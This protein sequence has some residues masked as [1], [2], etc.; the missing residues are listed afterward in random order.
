MRNWVTN[1]K[2]VT[3]RQLVCLDPEEVIRE[4]NLGV[5]ALRRTS[6]LFESGTGMSWFKLYEHINGPKALPTPTR[7]NELAEWLPD[8]IANTPVS[9]IE[10]GTR[11]RNYVQSSKLETLG[12]VARLRS[13]DLAKARNLGRKSIGDA[14]RAIVAFAKQVAEVDVF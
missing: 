3:V 1:N 5:G 7:W 10:F 12:A 2:L 4:R 9:W 14:L 13:R 8:D 11:F 6:D